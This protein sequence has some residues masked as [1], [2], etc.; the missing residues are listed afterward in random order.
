MHGP[1][2]H[3]PSPDFGYRS[4]LRSE[5]T[6]FFFLLFLM[7]DSWKQVTVSHPIQS[8]LIVSAWH[9]LIRIPLNTLR[10]LST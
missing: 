1:G 5:Q 6:D 9:A 8:Q 2:G 4:T 7:S 3:A 10:T